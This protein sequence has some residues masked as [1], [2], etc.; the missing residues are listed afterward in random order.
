MV[1]DF[2][3]GRSKHTV[4]LDRIDND[5]GYTP[6]NCVFCSLSV[7]GGKKG[8]PSFQFMKQMSFNF[9]DPPISLADQSAAATPKP[10]LP[11]VAD[12]QNTGC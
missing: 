12:G 6:N 1:F 4:S 10:E 7:D 5:Q 8:Q 11:N 2:G 3:V 9:P